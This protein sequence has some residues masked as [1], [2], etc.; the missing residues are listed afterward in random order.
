M[1]Q[2]AV[3]Y[4]RLAYKYADVHC[5]IQGVVVMEWLCPSHSTVVLWFGQHYSV[6]QEIFDEFVVY[7]TSNKFNAY[8]CSKD[9]SG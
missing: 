2:V 3:L 6:L 4:T 7:G 9:T 8:M 1:E 5:R